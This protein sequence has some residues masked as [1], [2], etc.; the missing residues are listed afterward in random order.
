MS[1]STWYGILSQP[2]PDTTN[3]DVH[4]ATNKFEHVFNQFVKVTNTNRYADVHHFQRNVF[5]EPNASVPF[6]NLNASYG[7]KLVTG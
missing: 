3:D 5:P 6:P 2:Y 1:R 7:Q 4:I